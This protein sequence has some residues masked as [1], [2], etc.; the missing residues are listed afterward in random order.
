MKTITL[1]S[2]NKWEASAIDRGFSSWSELARMIKISGFMLDKEQHDDFHQWKMGEGT[3][4][5]LEEIL[6]RQPNFDYYQVPEQPG[7]SGWHISKVGTRFSAV[8]PK[9]LSWEFTPDEMADIKW[10]IKKRKQY[11]Y[12]ELAEVDLAEKAIQ[13]PQPHPYVNSEK[14]F[15]GDPH[16]QNLF[17]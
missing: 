10:C 11:L 3:K 14:E 5:Q 2:Q 1:P 4:D 15:S 9:D 12:A 17:K 7:Y 6:F 13:N 8:D 16:Q